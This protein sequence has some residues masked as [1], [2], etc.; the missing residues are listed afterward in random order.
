MADLYVLGSGG[1]FSNR[2]LHLL[3]QASIKMSATDLGKKFQ[4]EEDQEKMTD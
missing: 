2:R 4:W 3:P 1:S